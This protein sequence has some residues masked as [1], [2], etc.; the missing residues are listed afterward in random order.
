MQ[1]KTLYPLTHAQRR[2][3]YSEK[4]LIGSSALN[5]GFTVKFNQ[6]MDKEILAEA[7]NKAIWKN[8]GLRLRLVEPD[9][10][11]EGDRGPGIQQ[12]IS[13]YREYKVDYFEAR[14]REEAERKV[15]EPFDLL[16]NDLFYFAILRFHEKK[17]GYLIKLHHLIG[18]GWTVSLLINEI[19]TIYEDLKQG[20]EIDNF[21]NPSYVKYISDEQEYLHSPQ[22]ARD[23]EFWHK[24]LV[25]PPGEVK[26]SFKRSKRVDFKGEKR[27]T[28]FSNGLQEELNK[29]CKTMD[30]SIFK[31]LLSALAVYTARTTIK[32]DFVICI[33]NH[34]RLTGD[35]KKMTGMFA[36]TVPIRVNI[37]KDMDFKTLVRN[38]G[39][40]VN[41]TIKNHQRFPFDVL[42]EEIR[43]KTGIDVGYFLNVTLVAI[44]PMGDS[45]VKID[46]IFPGD[47][48]NPL[49]IYINFSGSRVG[50]IFEL[51]W[52]YQLEYFNGENVENLHHRLET[53]L[54]DC[55]GTPGKRIPEIQLL[56]DEERKKILYAFNDTTADYP[57]D[58]TIH[59]LFEEQV[60]R[61]PVHI[62]VIGTVGTRHL[63]YW[64]LNK[65]SDQLA[66][67]LR[68]KNVRPNTIVGIMME[69]SVEMIIGILAILKAGGA[70]LPIDPDYPEER[71]H[72][73]L[74]DSNA[75]ILLTDTL[76]EG[77]HFNSQ[78][79][80][81]NS[82]LLMS[83]LKIPFHHSSF[84]T[85]HSS[86]LVYILYTSGST[87]RPKGVM[88]EHHSA[89]NLLWTLSR[90]YPLS[91]RDRY[92]FKTS[93]LFDVSVSEL[94]GWFPGGGSLVVL[95]KDEHREPQKII[96]A[97]EV[98]YITHINFVPSMFNVFL[99][100]LN[101][102]NIH[103]LASLRYIFLAG[104]ELMPELVERFRQLNTNIRLENLYGPT[105]A[106]VYASGFSLSQWKGGE[107]IPIGKP[108]QNTKLHVLGKYSD[109]LPIGV[110]GELCISGDGAALGYLNRPELTAERFRVVH[111]SYRSYRSYISY[112]TGDLARWLPDGNIEF[113]G[114]MDHQVKIRGYR[115]EL[116][117]IENQ[118]LNHEKVN[119][120]VVVAK[121]EKEGGET[122]LAAY[123]VPR[124]TASSETLSI[125]D[126]R[127][128]LSEKL[129]DYMVPSRFVMMEKLPLTPTGK[130]NRL[131]LPL[132]AFAGSGREYIPPNSEIEKKL[133]DI[134]AG[135][136]GIKKKKISTRD[137]F[138]QL[139]GHSLKGT[140]VLSSIH[141]HFNVDLSLAKLFNAPT[142]EGLARCIKE[143]VK[144][145]Y[146]PIEAVE[147][148]EYYP[149]SSAQKRLYV[150]HQMDKGGT[151]NNISPVFEMEGV[152]PPRL[153]DAFNALIMRHESFRTS[154]FQVNGEPVQKVHQKESI[155]LQITKMI[156]NFVCPF[157]LSRAP[158]LRAG[159]MKRGDGKD[160]LIVD[161]HHII[162]DG[163][164]L[165]IFQ[166]EL[167]ELYGSK[168]MPPLKIQYK[169]YAQWQNRQRGEN[170]L[171][172][173]EDYWLEQFDGEIPV[174]DLPIDYLRPA[175]QRFEG[176]TIAFE[177][178][179]RKTKALKMYAGKESSTLFMVLMA[180]FN[181]L[182]GK[183]SGQ[184]DIVVGT[185]VAGRRHEQLDHM[186]GMFVNT[187]A[188]RSAPT[189]EKRFIDFL[190][191]TR[192]KT[193]E[194][195]ENQDYPFEELVEKTA[196][197]RDVGRNPLFDV[198]FALEDI[199]RQEI[200]GTGMT[201]RFLKY[202]TQIA[203][204]DMSLAAEEVGDKLSFALEY[205]SKLFKEETIKRFSQCFKTIISMVLKEPHQRIANIEIIPGEEKK[206]ILYEFNDTGLEYPKAKTIHRLF[207]EQVEKSPDRI[208]V[209]AVLNPSFNRTYRT[210]KTYLTYM[211]YRQLDKR[212]DQ[213]AHWLKKK[214]VRTGTRSSIVSIR[215]E[216]CS[217]IVTGIFGILKAGGAYLPVDPAIP[218]NRKQ[219]IL[220]D[221]GVKWLLTR[222]DLQEIPTGSADRM[223]PVS[224]TDP[225]YVLYTSGSTG[226]PKGVMV[227]HSA[228]VNRLYWLQETYR[229]GENDVI[230][231]KTPFT[232]DVSVCELFRWIIG[233]GKVCLLAPGSEKEPGKIVAAITK[234]KVTTADFV[235]SLLHVFLDYIEDNHCWN[236]VSTLRWVFVGVEPVTLELV[237]KFNEGLNKRF[238]TSLINAFGLTETTVDNTHFDCSRSGDFETVPIGK[239]I[240]NTK[241]YIVDK[242]QWLQPV[243]VPGEL[244]IAGESLAVGYLNKP[245]L[246]HDKFVEDPF[247][248]GKIMC[249][250]GDFARWLPDGNVT[251]IGRRD[252]QVKIR[253]HRVEL[254]EI[255][256]HL[257]A[258]D[259]VKEAVVIDKEPDMGSVSNDR[260]L[261]AYIVFEKKVEFS[262]LKDL[263]SK[264]LPD[265]MI[266]AFFVSLE[267]IPVTS[268]GK[269]DR[270]TLYTMT[271][272]ENDALKPG[273]T[274][275]RDQ[276]E[277]KLAAVWAEVL[278]KE[279]DVIGINHNFF[280]WGG[281]SLKAMVMAARIQKEF[282]VRITLVEIFKM[283]T[284]KG[285][286]A[287]IKKTRK[288]DTTISI[289]PAEKK[290]YYPLSSAQKRLYILQQM[291]SA[292]T[293]YNMPLTLVL[294]GTLE[295]EKLENTFKK[296]INRHDSLRTSFE[297]VDHTPVQRIHN[298]VSFN[299]Q[300][301]VVMDK[302][303]VKPF[304]LSQAPLLRVGLIKTKEKEH[305]LV[306]DM[307]HIIS[308]GISHI[309]L[310]K[311]FIALYAGGDLPGLKLQYKDFSQ[312]QNQQ[313]MAGEMEKQEAYWLKEFEG[314]IPVLE[315]PLDYHRAAS[316]GSEA[317]L[318]SFQLDAGA[319]G[320]LRKLA[321][322][323][324]TSLFMVFFALFN[325]LLS[326]L[327]GQEDIVVGTVVTGRRYAE[328]EPII[329][330]FVNTLP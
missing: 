19:N 321:K 84:I 16:D 310:E 328:L 157:D 269:V 101:R 161:M 144:D 261:C 289:E 164:S 126:L 159:L 254:G 207:E 94:F 300:Y 107:S 277:K 278:G 235:P 163:I 240:G 141:R 214:G 175:V 173:Q 132:P 232:F 158:L 209:A 245:E 228:V 61:M 166:R 234:E 1:K 312:W 49:V 198:M 151:V 200:N 116:G 87:G 152:E 42:V 292:S 72:Y 48:A 22:A 47:E 63:T 26:L 317:N 203:K 202:E 297:L 57:K 329:G 217:E 299:I 149:L 294:K 38:L 298:K 118:L 146:I 185:P 51:E 50:S 221:S 156:Q 283:P 4:I 293:A 147:K 226:K 264:S 218:E 303:L 81:V 66:H 219:F 2:I 43:E 286:A 148:K 65:K 95:G 274:A 96:D 134:W 222:Q 145:E 270:K 324:D 243:G 186:I 180:L 193:L 91:N 190:Q 197:A 54:A 192:K 74:K 7:I 313:T 258:M 265:Y 165:E 58:K 98:F 128:Y 225:A 100:I 246:T 130:V 220:E 120:A 320:K 280:E 27:I 90:A 36:S 69:R 325:V 34:N 306:V 301:P 316:Q 92:L 244:C 13:E 71:V 137:N 249:R 322:Q 201:I 282:N 41:H 75:R 99:H 253:G 315:M 59:G 37:K 260:F 140:M 60:V 119:E 135:A 143:A 133:V 248:F 279:K 194:A 32:E 296:L 129:P 285:M 35:Q 31:V 108:I 79:L 142:V 281:H 167:V 215:A 103:Q 160:I 263:L 70:Y 314:E 267:S 276:V 255:E 309:I 302:T 131:V 311:E 252:S 3:W 33:P 23:R 212:S 122:Y 6:P 124:L 39:E 85:H 44:P 153:E 326:K 199:K 62:A 308:D 97:I 5:I 105:E 191:E 187:L 247:S 30:T 113:L 213:V 15:R 290:D 216:R 106:T 125:S 319:A 208:A 55:L 82:Q 188:L 291:H 114:R 271:P 257:R 138:F 104:E 241:I 179:S 76:S 14:A 73:M 18:D 242:N 177:L 224:S 238:K 86:S 83:S 318:V 150:L 230:L 112:H 287:F 259:F 102:F 223:E 67:L 176:N 195:F 89:V 182:L 169:D 183:L 40:D 29:Y 189:G 237:K 139:G 117:E 121:E 330:M 178:S 64:G 184:E 174:L 80:I 12:Y 88:V 21:K 327:S 256:N 307:H 93:F 109:F 273:Y 111:R 206:R 115:V 268:H 170:K 272:A 233:G 77:H 136:L 305:I 24:I 266:P 196:A 275:P 288:D 56:S 20:R 304:V 295:K 123:V 231:Q 181:I 45:N 28:A 110:P 11:S 284:I 229:L 205:S 172:K 236:D 127:E 155:T 162:S 250:T 323:E 239:P 154:F 46:Y 204:F 8:E 68:A 262:R 78:L 168:K 53:I 25:P 227:R 210:Y 251:F 10:V 52:R 211:T 17:S 171:K 9:R